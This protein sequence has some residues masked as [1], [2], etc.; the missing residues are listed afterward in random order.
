MTPKTK[1]PD[2]FS[3]GETP[4]FEVSARESLADAQLRRN[5]GK[6]TQTIRRKRA[7]AVEEMPDWEELR[8][9]GRAL[10]ERTLRHLATYLLQL[11]VSVTRAG[12]V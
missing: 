2:A 8:E 9:A 5:L 4:T 12:G 11:E 3:P 7:V 1:P 10:K 6:A